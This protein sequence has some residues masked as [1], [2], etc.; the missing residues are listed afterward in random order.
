MRK[1]FK[2]SGALLTAVAVIYFLTFAIRH[3]ESLPELEWNWKVI[4]SIGISTLIYSSVM[5]IGGYGWYLLLRSVKEPVGLAVAL[6]IFSLAQ[7]AK[8]IPGNVGHHIGRVALA[9]S[10]GLNVARVILTMFIESGWV[11]VSG[12]MVA[13]VSIFV[14]G[15]SILTFIPH[16]PPV[17]QVALAAV[18]AVFLPLL[19]IWVIK[20]WLGTTSKKLLGIDEVIIPKAAT[21]IRCSLLYILT[22]IIVGAI[23]NILAMTFFKAPESHILFLTGLFS[24]AWISGFIVP[25]APAGLGIREVILVT[26]LTPVYGSGVAVSLSVALRVVTTSGDGLAFAAALIAQR[27]AAKKVDK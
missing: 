11:I 4:A 16:A 22:F 8:Y 23:M 21:L 25:G 1:V 3:V 20:R 26:G 27:L 5:L 6:V 18:T 9:K 12:A 24:V 2:L 7:F 13:L 14:S 19:G 10:Y 17:W 15:Q